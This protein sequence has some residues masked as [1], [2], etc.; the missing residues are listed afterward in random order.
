MKHKSCIR[1]EALL[2]SYTCKKKIVILVYSLAIELI[3]RQSLVAFSNV[4]DR[5][6]HFSIFYAANIFSNSF[7]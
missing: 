4:V 5:K 7:C 6:R 2:Y 1:I 3:Y